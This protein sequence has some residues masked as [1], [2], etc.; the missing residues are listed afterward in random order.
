MAFPKNLPAPTPCA[1][2]RAA[3]PRQLTP[4]AARATVLDNVWTARAAFVYRSRSRDTAGSTTNT[5]SG[6]RRGDT[7]HCNN[8]IVDAGTRTAVHTP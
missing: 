1:G 5:A 4:L 2:P 6:E 7:L 8:A 3:N